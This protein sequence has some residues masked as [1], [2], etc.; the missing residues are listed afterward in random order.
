MGTGKSS[1]GKQLAGQLG[2]QFIDT[3]RLIIERTGAPIATLFAEKGEEAFRD[4]ESGI[5]TSIGH[6]N[7]CVI[8]TGGGTVIRE[9]NRA[10]L[11]ALG[12]VVALTAS[13]EVIFN[14]VSRNTKRPLLQTENPR[15]TMRALLATRETYYREAAEFTLDTTT[16]PH[17]KAVAALI[18]KARER[19]SWHHQP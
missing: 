8:S 15:E 13:E 9:E 17:A 1:I 18:A 11:R 7:R 3:D 5:L 6:L 16:L 19:F 4:I 2:F 12:F 10:A 14:R